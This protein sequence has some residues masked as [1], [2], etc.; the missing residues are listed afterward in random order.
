M[1]F[2]SHPAVAVVVAT[3]TFSP[4]VNLKS[5]LKTKLK[6][7]TKSQRNRYLIAAPLLISLTLQGCATT[8]SQG[9]NSVQQSLKNTF[10]SDDPCAHNAR[11]IGILAGAVVGALVGSKMADKK[12]TGIL[13]GL[14]LGGALG[15]FIG[16]EVDKRE[17][18]LSKIQA[19]YQLD[20][21]VLPLTVNQANTGNASTNNT[22]PSTTSQKVGLSVSIVN[23]ENKPQFLSGSDTLE[24]DAQ[25]QFGEIANQYSPQ[26]QMAQIDANK[27][28][29]EKGKLMAELRKK[30]ILLIG[31]TD[32]TG[33]SKDNAMLSEKRAKAVAKIFKAAG[34]EE[35]Q[36]YYQGAGETLPAAD[37]STIEG[38]AK[39]RRVEIVDLTNEESFNLYLQ[40]R[41]AKTEFYR[42]AEVADMQTQTEV[43]IANK[44]TDRVVDNLPS[45][46]IS[47]KEKIVANV[48]PSNKSSMSLGES[49]AKTA[50]N[51]PITWI[52]FGGTQATGQN[53]VIQLGQVKQSQSKFLF[54]GEAQASDLSTISS[55]NLDRPREA[56]AVKSL[57]NGKDYTTNAHL[58]SLNG[59]SWQDTVG[60]HLIVLNRV[61]VL[62]EGATLANLPELK[63]YTNY[64]AST[65]RNA[66]PD[67]SLTPEVNIYQ[68]SNGL[69]YRIFAQGNHGLQCM[70]VLMPLDNS[71]VSKSGKVVYG[72]KDHALVADFKP[73]MIR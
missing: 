17:C 56:G 1:V 24:A 27:T 50:A 42:A 5:K 8:S 67:V 18:E 14:G 64:N 36:L 54:I 30:R 37:N 63:V 7:H 22:S 49:A 69:L 47:V 55:C 13:V 23:Q 70:D 9:G 33:N 32:D 29:E 34:V 4:K 40:N 72:N 31:H 66:K 6:P 39:N 20:M 44:Q 43:I 60:G 65:N 46:K 62:R 21:Q 51:K 41:R 57:I 12:S 2:S 11:N 59:R 61:A 38:R 58:P 26:A 25:L 53:A 71:G 73:S 52:D 68:G 10:A 48:K 3:Q 28:P 15:A 16:S 19:K 45:K 35:S